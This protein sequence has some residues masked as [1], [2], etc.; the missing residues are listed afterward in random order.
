MA[1]SARFSL[2]R[3]DL[4]VDRLPQAG[5]S[6]EVV[7]LEDAS[8]GAS[9][10]CGPRRPHRHDYHELIWTRSGSGQHLVDGDVSAVAPS[11][12]M[13]IARGQV[14]VFERAAGLY[15][16]VVRFGDELLHTDATARA[17]P[18][19][20][21]VG[22]GARTAHVP[23]GDVPRLAAVIESLAAETVRPP[24]SRTV[25]LQRHILAAMLLWIERWYEAGRAERRDA[26]DPGLQLYRRFSEVLEREFARHPDAGYY[27]DE[28]GVPH[29]ALS[30]ALAE[31]TGRGT[32]A[33]ITDRRML[34]A[35]RLLRFTNLTVG[36]VAFRAG[37]EDPLYFSR[38]FKRHDGEPPL[39][40]RERLRGRGDQDVHTST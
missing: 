32:K 1:A 34:E 5:P 30:R 33:L 4:A 11:T 12:I 18:K 37:F 10:D 38:A 24:D 9:T 21:L 2:D 22:R 7:V 20:L 6:V 14:H 8:Y 15:G 29:A 39:A 28:L 19:W 3:R 16:A 13:L 40:Y 23:A 35:A 26:D 31:V 36:E 27:A 17:S 25:D